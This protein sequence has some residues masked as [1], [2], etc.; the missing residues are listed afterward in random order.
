MCPQQIYRRG[1]LGLGSLRDATNCQ[2]TGGPREWGGLEGEGIGS[3]VGTSSWRGKGG[4]MDSQRV[5][6]SE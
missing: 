6:R 1:L 4:G 5:T 2:E 3:G